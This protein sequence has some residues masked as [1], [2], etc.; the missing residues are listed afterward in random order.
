MPN[1]TDLTFEDD[2]IWFSWRTDHEEDF[3]DDLQDV[4]D[5]LK[6]YG[7]RWSPERKEWHVINTEEAVKALELLFDNGSSMVRNVR[8]QMDLFTRG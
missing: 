5:E 7:R 4:K 8:N 2:R 6:P 1:L 3:D